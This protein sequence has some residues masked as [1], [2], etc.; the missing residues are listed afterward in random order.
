MYRIVHTN[1]EWYMAQAG[2]DG[3]ENTTNSN[4]DE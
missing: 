3:F 2:D 1:L 4:E